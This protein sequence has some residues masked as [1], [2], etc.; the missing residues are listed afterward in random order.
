MGN[1][2]YDNTSLNFMNQLNH[3][4]QLKFNIYNLI[5]NGLE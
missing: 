4:V 3:Q 1:Y 2:T 5:N